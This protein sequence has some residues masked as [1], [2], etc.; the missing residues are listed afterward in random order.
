M[1]SQFRRLLGLCTT[2]AC[3][4]LAVSCASGQNNGNGIFPA[5]EGGVYDGSLDTSS[6]GSVGTG[7]FG[8]SEFGGTGGT[9]PGTGGSQATGGAGGASGT[10]GGSGSCQPSFCPTDPNGVGTQCC[11][12]ANGP[13]G[14]NFGNGCQTSTKGDF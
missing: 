7:G 12:T 14:L 4:A 5:Q 6:G 10:G 2:A 9:M 8:G 1:S 3:V 13:C 11:M